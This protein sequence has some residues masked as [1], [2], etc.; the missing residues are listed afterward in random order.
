MAGTHVVRGDHPHLVVHNSPTVVHKPAKPMAGTQGVHVDVWEKILPREGTVK[1]SV[2]ACA[3]WR[4]R[5]LVFLGL[6]CHTLKYTQGL[7]FERLYIIGRY[8]HSHRA[9]RRSTCGA[10]CG[11]HKRVKGP[12][13]PIITFKQDISGKHPVRRP[14]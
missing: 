12:V 9:R 14:W 2:D 4:T 1:D 8:K 11:P 5:A 13:T 7:L 10:I 3:P 6:L